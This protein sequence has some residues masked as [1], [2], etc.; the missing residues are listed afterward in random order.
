MKGHIDLVIDRARELLGLD[1]TWH[2]C[3]LEMVGP[4]EKRTAIKIELG[5]KKGT[6]FVKPFHAIHISLREEE[7]IADEWARRTGKCPACKGSGKEVAS[8]S[9]QHGTTWRACAQCKGEGRDPS[10]VQAEQ[11]ALALEEVA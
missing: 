7:I 10:R 3:S 2:W 11:P 6:R 4:L 8:I 5:Q 9:V 1:E